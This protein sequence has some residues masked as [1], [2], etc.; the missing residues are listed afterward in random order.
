MSIEFNWYLPTHGDGRNLTA[1]SVNLPISDLQKKTAGF[2]SNSLEYLIDVARAAEYAGFH[3]ILIPTGSTCHDAW[4]LT[5]ALARRTQRLKFLVAFRPGF[6]LPAVAAQSVQTLQNITGDRLLLNVVTGGN[7]AEQQSYGDFL[8]HDERYER[9]SEFLELVEKVWAGRSVD[10]EGEFYRLDQGGLVQPLR[11]RPRIYFGGSSAPAERVAAAH[12]DVYLQWGEP[13][14]MVK[15]RIDRVREEAARLNRLVKFGYR[16]HVITR[17]TEDEAWDEAD[18]LLQAIPKE[19]IAQSQKLLAS[20]ESVGQARM[21]SLHAQRKFQ[22]ARDLE[23]HP[24][25]WAGVGLVRGGAGTA[26]VGSHQQVAE[27]IQ[28]LHA[29]GID[30]FILSGYPN[31]EEALRFGSEVRP[32]LDRVST[33]VP[34]FA[35]ET[36][37]HVH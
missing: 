21:R 19:E 12:A 1:S 18:R 33:K 16:V 32:L 31:L 28:E 25:L 4:I 5:A 20:S 17:D 2:R 35:T 37:Q 6:V 7:A 26:L 34:R 10:H 22:N 11:Q 24:N 3:A 8:E 27:R 36:V 23:I 14:L 13:P 29:L 9:T 30:S 15:E